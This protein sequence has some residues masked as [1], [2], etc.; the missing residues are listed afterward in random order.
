MKAHIKRQAMPK[1]WDIKRKKIRFVARPFPGGKFNFGVPLV[2]I[3]RDI[4][5]KGKT[6][7]EVKSILLNNEVFVNGVKRKEI[8][9]F[10]GLMDVLSIPSSKEYFR[11][12]V[13]KKSEIE[14]LSITKEESEKLLC[15]IINKSLVKGKCQ[16]NLH[17][18]RNILIDQ[19][20][21]YNVGDSVLL[22]K[23]Q[24]KECIKLEKDS[25]AYLIGGK[26]IGRIVAIND[27]KDKIIKCGIKDDVF[28]VVK[29]HIFVVGKEKP[30][31]SLLKR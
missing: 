16:L 25:L 31:I 27:I 15:K 10:V 9:F 30:L 22:I 20:G 18:G 5:H 3:L 7:K 23:N 1:T 12:L 4:L 2:V 21:E 6:S 17:N 8:K 11:V 26:H 14:I 13:N 24:I 28:D 29:N 19:K